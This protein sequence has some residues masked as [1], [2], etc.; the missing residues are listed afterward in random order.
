MRFDWDS[1]KAESNKR[2]HGVSFE[3]ART[4]F[5][6]AGALIF[7]DSDH[8]DDE[9]R[10][11]LMGPDIAGRVLVVVHCYRQDDDVVRIISARPATRREREVFL[12]QGGK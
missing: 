10:F 4:V 8:S 3:E 1:T 12:E 9:E 6:E 11:L 5:Y 2:K 7:D